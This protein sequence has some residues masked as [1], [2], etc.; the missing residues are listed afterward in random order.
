MKFFDFIRGK[1]ILAIV[2][3][4][5]A[6][7]LQY[8]GFD[9]TISDLPQFETVMDIVRWLFTVLGVYGLGQSSGDKEAY[10]DGKYMNMNKTKF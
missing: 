5:I 8:F 9:V 2:G 7:L 4:I 3:I 6:V 10:T 1:T